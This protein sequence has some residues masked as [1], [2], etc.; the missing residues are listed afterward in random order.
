MPNSRQMSCSKLCGMLVLS[1]S[2]APVSRSSSS[3]FTLTAVLRRWSW[4]GWFAPPSPSPAGSGGVLG[5]VM[6][7]WRAGGEA[8]RG[9]G[10]KTGI[11]TGTEAGTGG[12]TQTGTGAGD[13]TE[14]VFV[15]HY[16]VLTGLPKGGWWMTG[17][18]MKKEKGWRRMSRDVAQLCAHG[19]SCWVMGELSDKRLGE[20]CWSDEELGDNER[21]WFGEANTEADQ[22]LLVT[23]SCSGE[24]RTVQVPGRVED[25]DCLSSP[26]V[27]VG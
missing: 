8:G 18:L 15:A 23:P 27:R 20:S 19:E 4:A 5:I 21:R 22:T 24:E 11:W 10:D 17:G 12:G 26:L 9:N 3:L 25:L 2:A 6:P 13:G 16:Q 1:V 7:C 14:D